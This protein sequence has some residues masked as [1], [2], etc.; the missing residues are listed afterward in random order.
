M[1]KSLIISI[2]IL[3]IFLCGCASKQKEPRERSDTYIA[4]INAF[5]VGTFHLY[6]SA[7]LG[8]PK[9]TDFIVY[10]SP[11]TNNISVQGK[12][13]VNSF[14]ATFSYKERLSLAEAQAK[15][16][17]AFETN[18]IPDIKPKAKNAYSKGKSTVMWG[19]LGLTHEAYANYY[20]N[21]QYL[22]PDKPYFKITCESTRMEGEEQISSPKV[23]IYISPTQWESIYEVCNQEHLL[24]MTDEILEEAQAF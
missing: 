1:K 17:A 11:R 6:A 13:G 10:F 4:D 9:I 14:Q 23:G 18:S 16:L 12:V 7:N 20:T 22:E 21:A 5:Q 3:C 15:Y 24:E 2:F 8:K 19:A